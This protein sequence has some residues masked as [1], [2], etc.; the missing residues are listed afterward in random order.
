MIWRA[1][2]MTGKLDSRLFLAIHGEMT[3]SQLLDVIELQECAADWRE[4]LRIHLA[5][6]PT[7]GQ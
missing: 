6:D 2:A 1:C 5:E 3:F 4:A 7:D